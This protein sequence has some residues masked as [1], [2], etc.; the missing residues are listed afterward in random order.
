MLVQM[1][2][3]P[4]AAARMSAIVKRERDLIVDFRGYQRLS[5][6]RRDTGPH[7]P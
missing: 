7:M 5:E 4:R 1:S 6:V 2:Q 3:P